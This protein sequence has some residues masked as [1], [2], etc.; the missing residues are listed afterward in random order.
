[1]G[2]DDDMIFCRVTQELHVQLLSY[3]A[4]QTNTDCYYSLVFVYDPDDD[5]HLLKTSFYICMF[6][7]FAHGIQTSWEHDIIHN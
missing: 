7:F 4:T 6:V 5:E 3:G 2:S 1:M